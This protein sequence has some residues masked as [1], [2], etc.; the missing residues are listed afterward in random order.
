MPRRKH[1]NIE[2]DGLPKLL[3]AEVYQESP[4]FICLL[5]NDVHQS[6][7]GKGGSVAEAVENWDVKLQAHLRNAG[8]EDPVV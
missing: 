6:V 2:L 3:G 8:D 7:V 4:R 1:V 5:P